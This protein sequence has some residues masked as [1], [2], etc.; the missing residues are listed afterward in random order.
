MSRGP[1]C[2]SGKDLFC[3]A[4]PDAMFASA[5]IFCRDTHIFC[6]PVHSL[7]TICRYHVGQ[8]A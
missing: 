7:A 3:P 8:A 2:F 5:G 6:A 1:F 4:W